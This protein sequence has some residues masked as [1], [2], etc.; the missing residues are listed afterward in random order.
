MARGCADGWV[1]HGVVPAMDTE[2]GKTP[3]QGVIAGVQSSSPRALSGKPQTARKSGAAP[4]PSH[5]PS[6]LHTPLTAGL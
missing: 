5:C 1:D 6:P 3:V 2:R 4:A